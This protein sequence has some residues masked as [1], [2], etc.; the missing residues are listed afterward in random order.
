[1]RKNFDAAIIG[2]GPNGF[3]AAIT[4]AQ[5]NL[6]VA[7][8]ESKT[9][10]GGGMRSGELTL[11]G[12]IHDICSAIHPL[13]VGSPFFRTLPLEQHGLQWIQPPFPLAHPFDDDTAAILERSIDNTCQTLDVDAR[14]YKSL[15]E[16][17]ARN[18]NKL[19]DDLLAPLHLPRHPYL[20]TCFGL[21]ALRSAIGLST[22]KF[23][24]NRARSLFLG[25]AAHSFLS[26]DRPLTAAFGLILGT[27][28]HAMGWPIAQG[29]SQKVADALASVFL[30][31]GGEIYTNENIENIDQLPPSRAIVCDITP[32]Q[33]L[34]I[35]GH[36]LPDGYIHKLEGYRYGPG[37]FKIDWALNAPIPWKAEHCKRAG[38]VHLGGSPEEIMES[39]RAVWE[40]KL[41]EKPFIIMAQQSLFDRTRAP[42]GMHTGWGYC[43]VPNGSTFDMTDRIE[44][45][46]ERFAPGFRDCVIVRSCMSTKQLEEYNSNYV[47]GDINGGVQDIYQLFTRP[48][49]RFDPYSTPHKGLYICSSSTPPG[50][51]VHGMCGYYAAKSVLKHC[52]NTLSS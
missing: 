45:Q 8:Y 13:G 3:A 34:K 6:S 16:P 20:M 33:L 32:R 52:F 19:A 39:E 37:V 40:G 4:L 35:A 31:L 43:H 51:G 42:D 23:K 46:I 30:S 48:T 2:S 15:M 18:W 28:G 44:S 21:L 7:I 27:L 9:T 11:P 49:M 29:G 47:G 5:A 41:S 50:G 17:F 10:I 36:H 26:L 14:A 1:M 12:F 22:T 24:G 38:T 25:M